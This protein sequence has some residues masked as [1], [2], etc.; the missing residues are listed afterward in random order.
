M[1]HFD[2]DKIVWQNCLKSQNLHLKR[3]IKADS[4]KE[5]VGAME[6]K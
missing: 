3:A 4:V 6:H 2:D 5:A 1:S